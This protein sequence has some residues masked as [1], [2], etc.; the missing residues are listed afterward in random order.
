MFLFLDSPNKLHRSIYDALG[1]EQGILVQ[2]RFSS[3]HPINIK[4]TYLLTYLSIKLCK[5][6]ATGIGIPFCISIFLL[7]F[8]RLC[9]HDYFS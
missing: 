1:I 8:N 5:N 3:I 2:S 4:L 7:Y 9:F 6:Y